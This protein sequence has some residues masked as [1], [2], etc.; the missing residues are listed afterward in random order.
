MPLFVES[1][2]VPC[3]LDAPVRANRIGKGYFFPLHVTS[4]DCVTSLIASS[5]KRVDF[6]VA[7]AS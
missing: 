7:G 4:N 2:A 5:T 6:R 3:Q 1:L